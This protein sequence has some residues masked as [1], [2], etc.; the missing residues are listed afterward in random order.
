M[1]GGLPFQTRAGTLRSLAFFAIFALILAGC[2][3]PP[4]TAAVRGAPLCSL[5]LPSAPKPL[6]IA[7][8]P[9]ALIPLAP[10]KVLPRSSWIAAAPIKSRLEPMGKVTRITVHHEAMGAAEEGSVEEVK[11]ELRLLRT[12]HINR[13]F[14]DIGYHYVIDYNGRIWEGRP[15]KY[16]GA[17]AGNGDAN[18]GNIGI[19]LLGNFEIQK[20]T[21]TQLS[22]LQ[23]LTEYLMK[24]YSLTCARVF[25]HKEIRSKYGLSATACPGRNLQSQVNLMRTSLA[26]ATATKTA[27]KS[28][29]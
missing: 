7:P 15:V 5:V 29:K 12:S 25:T 11:D 4:T 16:Q 20:P 24:R 1:R 6:V 19:V 23:T 9:V 10:L 22:S 27:A 14:A 17:H 2:K 8:E 28:P 13:S 18:R 3:T 26:E 21:K